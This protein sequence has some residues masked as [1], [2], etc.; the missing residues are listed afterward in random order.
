M[1]YPLFPLPRF[2][3]SHESDSAAPLTDKLTFSGGV[4]GAASLPFPIVD[5]HTHQ[6]LVYCTARKL[7]RSQNNRGGHSREWPRR[8]TAK[9][10]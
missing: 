2:H 3:H 7:V 6:F 8:V 1:I 9:K 10:K 4:S 5:M